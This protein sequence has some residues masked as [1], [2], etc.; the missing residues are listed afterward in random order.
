MLS[1]TYIPSW[2]R[3]LPTA[4]MPDYAFQAWYFHTQ[5]TMRFKAINPTEEWV[6][7]LWVH[8]PGASKSFTWSGE[9]KK[10]AV[11]LQADLWI[12]SL[13]VRDYTPWWVLG[14]LGAFLGYAHYSM[15]FHA[16]SRVLLKH[17]EEMYIE[18]EKLMRRIGIP[19]LAWF[20]TPSSLSWHVIPFIKWFSLEAVR[21][22]R[23]QLYC[24]WRADEECQG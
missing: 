23:P 17:V 19:L 21:I 12:L 16:S 11:I 6:S 18:N 15:S 8:P 10:A 2:R 3:K 22:F 1:R 24:Y 20:P 9:T 7:V 13:Q 4:A 14:N 5:P